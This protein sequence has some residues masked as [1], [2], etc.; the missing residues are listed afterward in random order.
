MLLQKLNTLFPKN[1]NLRE[2]RCSRKF[3]M[4][5]Q[6]LLLGRQDVPFLNGTEN[7]GTV[8]F[9]VGRLVSLLLLFLLG[10]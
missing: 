8:R 10:M 5:I 1:I 2:R 7:T 4:F 3:T 6:R 9:H